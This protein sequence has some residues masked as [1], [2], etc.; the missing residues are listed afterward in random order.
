MKGA[1]Q[2]PWD[3]DPH[4]EGSIEALMILPDGPARVE[5]ELFNRLG[6]EGPSSPEIES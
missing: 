2:R 5:E 3:M 1:G 6:S 4:E